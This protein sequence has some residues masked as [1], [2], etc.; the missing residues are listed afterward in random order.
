MWVLGTEPRNSSKSTNALNHCAT[1]LD[2]Y[3]RLSNPVS[4]HAK[5]V[6]LLSGSLLNKQLTSFQHQTRGAEFLNKKEGGSKQSL[7]KCWSTERKEMEG[8]KRKGEKKK[9]IF[10]CKR[11]VPSPGDE[12]DLRL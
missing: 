12:S 9:M 11:E 1:S 2:P 4:F 10:S 8:R 6:C 3:S 7:H 5:V